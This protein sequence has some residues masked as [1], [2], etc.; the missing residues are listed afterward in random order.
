LQKVTGRRRAQKMTIKPIETKYRGYRFRSRL[1]ARWA[2]FLDAVGLEWVYEKEGFRLPSGRWY[3]PDFYIPSLDLWIEVKPELASPTEWP[4]GDDWDDFVEFADGVRS[5]CVMLCGAPGPV[6]A[7]GQTNS[8]QGFI[9]GDCSYY[10]CECPSCGAV[11]VQFDGRSARNRHKAGCSAQT[12]NKGYCTD[13]PLILAAYE[14]AR[15]AR[16]EHGETPRV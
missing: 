15:S 14:K 13:S 12:G 2:V 9:P 16:F 7:Y 5:D 4:V 6:E 3:L 11:G 1:E 10:W 8:Y